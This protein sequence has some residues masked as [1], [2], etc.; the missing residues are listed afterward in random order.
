M[1]I[2][3][4]C[5]ADGGDDDDDNNLSTLTEN[6]LCVS[7]TSVLTKC[8]NNIV[9]PPSIKLHG[10]GLYSSNIVVTTPITS[11]TTTQRTKSPPS[12]VM[13]NSAF[14]FS[15]WAAALDQSN[16]VKNG[17]IYDACQSMDSYPYDEPLQGTTATTT[18][19]GVPGFPD[20]A[21]NDDSTSNGASSND[22]SAAAAG[23]SNWEARRRLESIL[24]AA[25]S[26]NNSSNV[27]R[28][29]HQQQLR[30]LKRLRR[31]SINLAVRGSHRHVARHLQ[32]EATLNNEEECRALV[33]WKPSRLSKN[34][35]H[36]KNQRGV[37]GTWHRSFPRLETIAEHYPSSSS[38]YNN[39]NTSKLGLEDSI[40]KK[41]EQRA[42]LDLQTGMQYLGL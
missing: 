42:L 29:N 10:K 18:K 27:T 25:S 9:L 31:K 21:W 26:S 16:E 35:I 36:R 32:E 39:N 24:A 22:A 20:F 34:K 14:S 13:D 3:S 2:E 5:S 4:T 15:S 8:P 40:E 28:R 17:K 12:I 7:S 23:L 41:K 37:K 6:S 38:T 33:V 30:R 19:I 1:A 11:S